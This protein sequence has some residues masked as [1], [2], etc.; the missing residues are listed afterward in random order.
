M[1]APSKAVFVSYASQD[2]EAARRLA[3]DLRAD[4][5]EVW[6]DQNELV[7]GD[8]W[9]TKIRRQIGACELFL[10]LI[11]ANTEARMEGYFRLEWK[12][13]AQRTHTMADEKAFLLPIVIDTTRDAAAK[14]PPEFKA[15]QW[16]KLPSGVTTP[17][18]RAR[19]Q[20]LLTAE[21]DAA[22]EQ[23]A[24]YTPA[25]TARR[26]GR[27]IGRLIGYGWAVLGIGMGVYFA[28]QPFWYG[29]KSRAEKTVAA[30]DAA[31]PA[32]T[33]TAP[34]EPKVAAPAVATAP[35]RDPQRVVLTRFENLTGDPELDGV[36]RVIEMELTRALGVLP[37][38]R[39]VPVEAVGRRAGR[40]AADEA[41]AASVVTGTILRAGKELELSAQIILAEGGD[42][43]G[44]LGPVRVSADDIRGPV[45]TEFIDRLTTG[46]HNG[47]A[48][49]ANPPTRMSA[50]V[51]N[52]P[53]PR[54]TDARR[55]MSIRA[56]DQSSEEQIAAHRALLAEAP[57][58]LRVKHDLARLL[59]DSERIDEAQALFNELLRQDRP[60]LAELEIYSIIYDEALLAGDPSRALTA[61]R[62]MVELRPISDAITQV[63]SCLWGQNR[64]RAAHD[65]LSAWFKKHG[66]GMPEAS[67]WTSEAGLL[68]T[69]GL[70]H[71]MEGRPEK[72]LE[73]MERMEQTLAGRAFGALAWLRFLALGDLGRV[74][75]QKRLVMEGDLQ[76]G[77]ARIDAVY[78]QF[79]GYQ[80]AKHRGQHAVAEEWLRESLA[81][82]RQVDAAGKASDALQSVGLWVLDAVGEH[83]QALKVVDRIAT[84]W[85]QSANVV[86]SRAIQLRALGRIE[87]AQVEEKKLEQWEPRNSRGLP[88]YWRARIAARAGEKERAVALLRQA[89][90]GGLW[91]GGFNSPSF[92]FGRSE[93]EFATLRGYAPYDELVQPKG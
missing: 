86:G 90:A 24:P 21:N 65:E 67:R 57:E 60:Q 72:T 27:S 47:A 36:A 45:L 31:T 8:A 11:S 13:A 93:P 30:S 9:D 25:G 51:Y 91:F 34:A 42:V 68:A 2:A 20:K 39:I 15:V 37:S 33:V 76:S 83:E 69:E 55:A 62:S 35:K 17:A 6:F 29:R 1:S 79:L 22:E 63:V 59:R 56:N 92:D 18:F 82:W 46:V 43:Y 71:L 61:A 53:W 41:G 3:E 73:A 74:A 77:I 84:R 48:T 28:T 12:I 80:R 66:A 87:E 88:L 75:E 32:P 85:G 81:S 16:T 54:W 64:P 49:L 52:R 70:M 40:A 58:M 10:P 78:L 23:T 4:G 26:E 44:T 19:V 89:I 50:V 7:G 5:I 38:A 14:V